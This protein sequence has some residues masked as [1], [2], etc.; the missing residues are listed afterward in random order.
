MKKLKSLL[1]SI[2]LLT[3]LGACS[4]EQD[5][6]TQA[7]DVLSFDSN[8]TPATTRVKDNKF[9]VNDAIGIFAYKAGTEE[10]FTDKLNLEH[11]L[12]S[13]KLFIPTPG[14]EIKLNG[15]DE[16]VDIIAYYPYTDQVQETTYSIDLGTEAVDLLYATKL[17]NV[18][19]ANPK[20]I[21][22]H[23]LASISLTLSIKED[24][25]NE[26]TSL[27]GLT[28]SDVD[29]VQTKASLD[30]LKDKL[31]LDPAVAAPKVTFNAEEKTA[32]LSFMVL[33]GQ[34]I[35]KIRVPFVL[36]NHTYE[37]S[38]ELTDGTTE[39]KESTIYRFKGTF[40]KADQSITLEP[41]TDDTTIG[42]WEINE[43]KDKELNPK[44]DTPEPEGSLDVDGEKEFTI[45]ASGVQRAALTVKA[46]E[47]LVWEVAS[48]VDWITVEKSDA[49]PKVIYDV[50]ENTTAEKRTGT[51]TL[52]AQD[53]APVVVTIHQDGQ[54]VDP[55]EQTIFEE[56]FPKLSGK[57][58]VKDFANNYKQYIN[59]NN[60]DLLYSVSDSDNALKS[61]ASIDGHIWYA[62]KVENW[63]KV[64]NIDIVGVKDLKVS[65]DLRK[66]G[67]PKDL[68]V[69]FVVKANG[70]TVLELNEKFKASYTS[71]VSEVF[72]VEGDQL[73]LE[74]VGNLANVTN[75][76]NG[77]RLDNI[78]LKGMK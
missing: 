50:L 68:V 34:D 60:L 13:E 14:N 19:I 62:A 20:L 42:D 59:E 15:I 6:A 10:Q 29:G 53:I 32:T 24:A 30:L 17:E 54:P 46:S 5:V 61:T 40:F 63:F 28:V 33:P 70:N 74:F 7:N 35:S 21:F 66:E 2:G 27:A 1:Y 38:P 52:T 36:D 3:L 64:E 72:Q 9:E 23:R 48:N 65:I 44:E 58:T 76:G 11:K 47:G 4:S 41:I 51:I 67:I 49:E 57:T 75:S 77:L 37:W 43:G 16:A 45:I 56:S 22:K 31:T 18:S 73:T 71:Y 26:I 55:V 12:N 25:A 78:L 39:I 8:I 69:N